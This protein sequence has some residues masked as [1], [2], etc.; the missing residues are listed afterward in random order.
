M[1]ELLMDRGAGYSPRGRKRVGHDLV[2][3]QQEQQWICREKSLEPTYQNVN[4]DF[5]VKRGIMGDFSFLNFLIFPQWLYTFFFLSSFSN[6]IFHPLC[7]PS[8]LLLPSSPMRQ[9]SEV[10]ATANRSCPKIMCRWRHNIMKRVKN[11]RNFVL[12]NLLL[13]LITY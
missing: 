2:T 10:H 6:L 1:K 3:K 5:S 12:V 7:P 13:I 11:T 8:L 4:N 9:W